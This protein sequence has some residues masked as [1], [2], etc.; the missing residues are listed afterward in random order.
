V[1]YQFLAIAVGMFTL[2]AGYLVYDGWRLIVGLET[3]SEMCWLEPGA[4]R[5]M[6]AV[7]ILWHACWV[8]ALIAHLETRPKKEDDS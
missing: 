3:I 1:T 5:W 2:E 4:A 7:V 6:V 8:G